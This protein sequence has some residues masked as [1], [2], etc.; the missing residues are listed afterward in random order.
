MTF[1]VVLLHHQEFLDGLCSHFELQSGAD[2]RQLKKLWSEMVL[3]EASW[4]SCCNLAY[5]SLGFADLEE[6]LVIYCISNLEV[7]EFYSVDVVFGLAEEI[8]SR[9]L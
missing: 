4:M 7:Y 6:H 2:R 9:L 8:L 1:E 3:H 5:L